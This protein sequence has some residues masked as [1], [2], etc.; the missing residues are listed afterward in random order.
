VRERSVVQAGEVRSA[1]IES[2]RALAALAV[3]MGHVY[4]YAHAWDPNY[5]YGT[6]IHRVILGGGSAV[7]VFFAL[8]GYLLFWPFA[9][10]YFAHGQAVDL[11][12]YAL[13][14]VL[15]ILPLYYFSVVVV[16]LVQE[17]GGTGGQWWRFLLL[18]E[19]FSTPTLG[20]VNGS[21]WSVIVEIH[22][23]ALLPLFAL[24]LAWVSRR[25]RLWAI[26]IL[27][28]I[29]AV[30]LRFRHWAVARDWHTAQLLRFSILTTFLFF[31]PGMLVAMLRLSWSEGPPRWLA[32][33]LASPAVWFL[34]AAPFWALHFHR[35][36]E[37][38]AAVGS[39]LIVGAC[40]LPLREARSVRALEWRPLA[41][42][43]VASYS[44]YVWHFPIVHALSDATHWGF[45]PLLALCVSVS[46][47]VAL[48]S[49]ALIEA[50]FL[51]LRR[52]WA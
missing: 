3:L 6:W 23:Y 7:F 44:I 18:A 43:G 45:V 4:G 20:H 34:A 48:V 30:D 12:R 9:K 41:A 22:F 15:R 21:L 50:P 1:R 36:S 2:L 42:L 19:N 27:L 31:V 16:L 26:V 32:G 5:I 46:S 17:H 8:S 24:A 28:V 25:R 47:I 37:W 35:Y 39:F 11:R 49:Y 52:R 33:P 10:R 51:R 13:N 29:A 14:R 40:V 38:P